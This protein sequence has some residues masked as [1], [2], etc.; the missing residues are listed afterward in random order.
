MIEVYIK[1]FPK[2]IEISSKIRAFDNLK[3]QKNRYSYSTFPLDLQKFY[4]RR[5]EYLK[6][7]G[8]LKELGIGLLN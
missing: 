1:E 8:F 5:I 6:Q 3:V 4:D 2:Y 7:K